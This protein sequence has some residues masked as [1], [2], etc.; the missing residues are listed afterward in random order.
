MAYVTF[1]WFQVYFDM[2][3]GMHYKYKIK[4]LILIKLFLWFFDAKSE[5]AQN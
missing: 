2:T 5:I 1:L 3:A 4:K